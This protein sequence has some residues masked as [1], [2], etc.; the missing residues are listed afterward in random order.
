MQFS[1]RN[2]IYRN[3]TVMSKSR[4]KINFV[5]DSLFIYRNIKR[6]YKIYMAT[7][8]LNKEENL[9]FAC[10]TDFFS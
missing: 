4:V 3:I 2:T 7:D 1:Y 9:N 10:V 6:A 5:A 8:A